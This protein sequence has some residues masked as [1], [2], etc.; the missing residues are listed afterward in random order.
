MPSA[1]NEGNITT[2]YKG[3]GDPMK[4]NNRRPITL[5]NCD[6]KIYTHI[7]NKRM[8]KILPSLIGSTQCGFVPGR[9]ILDNIVTIDG[10]LH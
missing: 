2:L 1:L 6:Y 8:L 10:I 4:L 5:L 3:K 7:I 9:M